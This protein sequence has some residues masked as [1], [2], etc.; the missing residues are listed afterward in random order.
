MLPFRA[1]IPNHLFNVYSPR[2]RFLTSA[3]AVI[4]A[5][6]R[7]LRPAVA[8]TTAILLRMVLITAADVVMGH[9]LVATAPV[10]KTTVVGPRHHE[11]ITTRATAIAPRLLLEVARVV[12]L[13]MIRTLLLVAAIP[14][15]AT[16]R[17]RLVAA[18]KNHTPMGMSD[19]PDRHHDMVGGTKSVRA[20]SDYFLGL[21]TSGI[22]AYHGRHL[23]PFR[24]PRTL[25]VTGRAC[26]RLELTFCRDVCH[27]PL[28][29]D[30]VR[31]P[32]SKTVI[33]FDFM[34]ERI[35][36]CGTGDSQSILHLQRVMFQIVEA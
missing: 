12:L 18:M 29:Q 2:I 20:T 36:A 30:Q 1:Q 22:N 10:E 32:I 25:T 4:V 14:K 27:E 17:H 21:A 31:G 28:K 34:C 24:S 11:T 16:A 13:W 9:L 35:D 23:Q 8:I 7:A 5:H 15:I 6:A 26:S 33:E 19:V 3:V